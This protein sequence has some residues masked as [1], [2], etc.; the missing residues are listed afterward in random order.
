MSVD[1]R[2]MIAFISS[3]VI[4]EYSEHALHVGQSFPACTF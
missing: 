4:R 3:S 1:G 2:L